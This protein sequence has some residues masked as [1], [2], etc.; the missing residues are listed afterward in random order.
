MASVKLG[1]ATLEIADANAAVAIQAHVDAQASELSTVRADS[2]KFQDERD[3]AKA[4]VDAAKAETTALKTEHETKIAQIR[5]DAAAG[6][7]ERI[8]LEVK[9]ATLVK[10]H[11]PEGKTDRQLRADGLKAL[12][13]EISDDKSDAYV[14][15]AFDIAFEKRGDT[16]R[17][18]TQT[19]ANI[20]AAGLNSGA[21]GDGVNN[22][23]PDL[24]ANRLMGRNFG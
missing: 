13:Q 6:V 16:S 20:L 9:V 14:A 8:A 11:K 12:G 17:K 15:A 10:D 19:A 5:A 24:D 23:I 22:E 3:A 2:K 4:A 21:R 18:P 1:N 7:R